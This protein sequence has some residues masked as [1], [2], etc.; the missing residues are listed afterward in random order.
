M[1]LILFLFCPLLALIL[2]VR[3]PQD[4]MS[5][6]TII[7]FWG[8]IGF[9]RTLIY[10]ED[11]ADQNMYMELYSQMNYNQFVEDRFIGIWTEDLNVLHWYVMYLL[12]QIGYT[13]VAWAIIMMCFTIIILKCFFLQKEFDVMPYNLE[14]GRYLPIFLLLLLF[15]LPISSYGVKFWTAM[16]LF[17][18]GS[19]TFLYMDNKKG[20]L[21]VILSCLFHYTFVYPISIALYFFCTKDKAMWIKVCIFFVLLGVV[22]TLMPYVSTSE[23]LSRK[24]EGYSD[25]NRG[26]Y[27]SSKALWIIGERFIT[28]I[29]SIIAILYLKTQN[30]LNEKS[31]EMLN[32]LYLFAIGMLPL[33][34]FYD[35]FDRF[36]RVFVYMTLF[37]IIRLI[38]TNEKVPRFFINISIGI[39][40]YHALVMLYL[41]NSDWDF[42]ALINN[43]IITLLNTSLTTIVK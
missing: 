32:F 11:A 43:P 18:W 5:K 7:L 27:F 34:S 24:I 3:K 28:V 25:E 8:I 17:F 16:L 31:K 30:I 15:F 4:S 36:S 42:I 21:L 26:E 40:S 41:R 10:S 29:F 1:P 39:F 20:I 38:W 22:Y 35:A 2:A 33:L 12:S 37:F 23:V 9:T 6:C 19:Y 14:N 13:A